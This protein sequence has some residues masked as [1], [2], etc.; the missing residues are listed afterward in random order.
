MKKE[1]V[2][3]MANNQIRKMEKIIKE[4]MEAV[5]QIQK[6]LDDGYEKD[7]TPLSEE[8]RKLYKDSLLSIKKLL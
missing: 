2:I 1:E 7:G 6:I 3:K 8:S 4:G 5:S